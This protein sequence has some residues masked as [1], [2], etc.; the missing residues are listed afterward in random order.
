[1]SAKHV[2]LGLSLSLAL[3]AALSA[4]AGAPGNEDAA[5]PTPATPST[6]GISLEAYHWDLVSAADRSGQA[7]AALQPVTGKPLRLDFAG[8]NV[9]V[10]GGCNRISGRF[11]HSGNALSVGPLRQTQMACADGRLMELDA[12]IAERLQGTLQANTRAGETPRLEL[13]AA[14]GDTL[15]FTGSPTP[16]TRYGR[17]GTIVFFEVAAQRQPCSHP[18]SPDMQCLQVRERT[19]ADDGMLASQ[20]EW[21]PLY[22]EIDGYT[23]TPGTRNVL[24]LKKFD[25][26][27]PPADASSVVY[28]LDMVVESELVDAK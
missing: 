7:I 2:P 24:R 12:A 22:Q 15:V 28:V 14:N 10:S 19:Y 11:T 6:A 21:Q 4:C 16:Q 1:M 25:V 18:L 20:G 3:T 13:I 17:E 9:G 27:N 8:S 5:K 23:H 26:K